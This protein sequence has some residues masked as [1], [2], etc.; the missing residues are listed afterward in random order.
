VTVRRITGV[1][2]FCDQ[3]GEYYDW[4][5]FDTVRDA[6]AQ[7]REEGWLATPSRTVCPECRPQDEVTP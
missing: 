5:L 6:R 3:C 2:I 4:T 1:R 7:I